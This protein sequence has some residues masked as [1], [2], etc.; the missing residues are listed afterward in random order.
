M[1]EVFPVHGGYWGNFP[2]HCRPAFWLNRYSDTHDNGIG[3]RVIS[4]ATP[5]APSPHPVKGGSWISAPENCRSATH[6][7]IDSDFAIK[8]FGFRV[9]STAP[10]TERPTPESP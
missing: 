7:H 5:P 8:F 4:T 9:I 3:F 2:K 6:N 10:M 1:T